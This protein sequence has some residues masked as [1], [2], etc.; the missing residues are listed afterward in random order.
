V[1]GYGGRGIFPS[2]PG[3][4]VVG[5]Y[6]TNIKQGFKPSLEYLRKNNKKG[7]IYFFSTELNCSFVVI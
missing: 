6:S 5:V 3:E 7:F 4:N 2:Q 1:T